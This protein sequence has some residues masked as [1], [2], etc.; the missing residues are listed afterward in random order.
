[1]DQPQADYFATIAQHMDNANLILCNSEPGWYNAAENSKA[2]R[3]LGYAAW[4][5]VKANKN[6]KIALCL[7]GD[8]HHYARYTTEF[9]TEFMTAGG[10]GA[11][12]HGTHQLPSKIE[13]NWFKH[14]NAEATLL[15]QKSDGTEYTACYPNKRTSRCQLLRNLWFPL[16]NRGFSLT[17][18]I[19]YALAG[20]L[21]L[22]FPVWASIV[23]AVL[24]I[25]LCLGYISY[26]ESRRTAFI[27]TMAALLAFVQSAAHLVAICAA[28]AFSPISM[29]C[30][31]API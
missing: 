5:A 18:G 17:L 21:L 24:L 26:Q 3:S 25:G 10:G 11:F 16:T 2:F 14:R 29:P 31:S 15:K 23:V 30:G 28:C 19:F 20:C 8:T 9:G 4:I 27:R 12:L 7:S 13:L 22:N 1:M 6:I